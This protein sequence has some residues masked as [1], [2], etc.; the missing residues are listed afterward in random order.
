M[1]ACWVFLG[2]ASGAALRAVACLFSK[3]RF[4][5]AVLV[6]NVIG[7]F[8]AGCF[9]AGKFSGD[10]AMALV[11]GFCG[12]LTTYST[13][14]V[15]TESLWRQSRCLAVLNAGL[16]L[17]GGLLGVFLGWRLGLFLRG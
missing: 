6:V 16:N 1:T 13:F 15:Q 7:S 5:W 4:P 14:A 8:L 17:L 10:A 9:V 2:G 3:S 11:V 12:G